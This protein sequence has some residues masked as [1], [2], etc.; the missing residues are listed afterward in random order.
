MWRFIM[1]SHR[2]RNIDTGTVHQL[3]VA[4]VAVG[5][6]EKHFMDVAKAGK[7]RQ[8]KA[9]FDR[10]CTEKTS[11][12]RE[13]VGVLTDGAPFG[14]MYDFM[15]ALQ[16]AGFTQSMFNAIISSPRIAKLCYDAVCDMQTL[17]EERKDLSFEF[18][19]G[20][21]SIKFRARFFYVQDHCLGIDCLNHLK[22]HG[23]VGFGKQGLSF[24]EDGF[25]ARLPEGDTLF[26][27]EPENL[28]PVVEDVEVPCIRVK[29]GS[30]RNSVLFFKGDFHHVFIVGFE[31]IT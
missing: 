22:T 3:A 30:C 15:Y 16:K 1:P 20:N 29:D 26:F 21:D 7:N 19:P 11:A 23:L 14:V 2:V 9:M 24:A 5:W 28:K 4:L 31:P 25:V 18:C 6:T 12:Q 13:K 8:A 17:F 10:I 27:D